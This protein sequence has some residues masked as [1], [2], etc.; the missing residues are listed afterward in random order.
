M[1]KYKRALRM[2]IKFILDQELYGDHDPD[3][4]DQVTMRVLKEWEEWITTDEDE[5]PAVE[6]LRKIVDLCDAPHWDADRKMKVRDLAA[7]AHNKLKF[8]FADEED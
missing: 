8:E 5:E 2:V 1:N 4:D 7:A 6:E 3:V